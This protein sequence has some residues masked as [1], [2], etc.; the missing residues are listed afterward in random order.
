M[1]EIQAL[2]A[3]TEPVT[4]QRPT[5]KP[6]EKSAVEVPIGTSNPTEAKVG[7]FFGKLNESGKDGNI[8]AK[9]E[10]NED[11]KKAIEG[12]EQAKKAFILKLAGEDTL[13]GNNPD[14]KI[15]GKIDGENI[16][17]TQSVEQNNK[18]LEI[19]NDIL[20]SLGFK[21][22]E[23]FSAQAETPVNRQIRDI[24]TQYFR[25]RVYSP[26]QI[27][28]MNSRGEYTSALEMTPEMLKNITDGKVKD[29]QAGEY[30]GVKLNGEQ[31]N[32]AKVIAATMVDVG[33]KQNKSPEEIHKAVVV[34]L[35]TAMQES[36]LKNI[37][38]G[39]RDSV[40]LFQQRPSCGWGSKEECKDP[41]YAT[42][43]FAEGLYKT[44]YMAKSV[45][46]A[47][48]SVQRSGFP[49]AYAKWQQM[50]EALASAM[51]TA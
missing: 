30:G 38:Y 26:A 45:T 11:Y 3:Y 40:G 23:T 48:Q 7:E 44:D 27:K 46:S 21:A 31:V 34:A 33:K 51:L 6:A 12:D 22:P 13:G 17:K 9:K 47:A 15:D 20:K 2:K 42:C 50:A 8:F 43:K 16:F 36:T 32:N 5:E 29:V 49:E 18:T 19:F 1:A 25:P 4:T 10:L 37:G 39:D 14:A 24:G 28:D 35:A 41:V